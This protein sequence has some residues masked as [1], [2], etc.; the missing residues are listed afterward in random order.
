M[1]LTDKQVEVPLYDWG[2]GTRTEP[3]SYVCAS[4]KQ[5]KGIRGGSRMIKQFIIIEE[6]ESFLHPS[7]QAEFGRVLEALA[8]ELKIQ[9]ICTVHC[10]FMLNQRTPTAN[11]LLE[12][13]VYRN[14]P[15]ESYVVS[16][17]NNW[18]GPL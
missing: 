12:R 17:G 9:I 4:G 2:S 7:G 10:P 11:I 15:K 3:I 18:I 16:S 13:K 1:I 6:P 5:D 14:K 8:E